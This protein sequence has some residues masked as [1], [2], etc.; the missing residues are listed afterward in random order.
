MTRYIETLKYDWQFSRGEIKNAALHTC[1]FEGWR[2]VRV[3]HDYAIEGPFDPANDRGNTIV[4]EDGFP[5]SN[6]AAGRT[7]ALPLAGTAWYR[8]TLRL[9][10]DLAGKEVSLEFDGVMSHC[11]I[12][13][14]GALVGKNIYG[15]TSFRVDVTDAVQSGDNLLAVRVEQ[16][17]WESRWYPGAGIYRNVRLIIK[18]ATSFAYHSVYLTTPTVSAENATVAISAEIARPTENLRVS[19]ALTAPD[20][21]SVGEITIP[22]TDGKIDAKLDVSTPKLWAHGTPNLY[23]ATL[24]LL[25]GDT[26]LD[27]ETLRFGIR[28]ILFDREIGCLVNGVPTR[29]KGV[30]MHHDLGAL[31][32]AVNEAALRRQFRILGEMGCNSIRTSHNPPT[33]ELLDMADELGFYIIVEQ[34]DQWKVNKT[35]NGYGLYF[36]KWA[37]FDLTSTVRRDRNHPSVILWSLGNEMGDQTA[38]DGGKTAKFLADIVRR[39]DPS[40]KITAGFSVIDGARTN[41]IVDAVDI[42]GL[43][44]R[45]HH[46]EFFHNT[47]KDILYGSETESCVSS[48]GVYF[49]PSEKAISADEKANTFVQLFDYTHRPWRR[50]PGVEI[51]APVRPDNQVSSYDL[52]A[53]N[54]A[55]FPEV[56]FAA[57]DDCPYVFGEYVWTGFDYLGEPTPY[58][59]RASQS[60][61]LSRSS[62][63]GIVDLAGLPKDRYYSYMARWTDKEVLHVFPHWNWNEGD[64]LPVHCYSSFDRAELFVNGRSLGIAEKKPQS[65]NCLERYRLIWNGVKFEP[66]EL[67]VK[68]L[69]KDGN[70]LKTT[71]VYTAEAPA[72]LELSADRTEYAADGDDLCF[73]T[74]RVLDAN[75]NPC[76]TATTRLRFSCEGAGELLATDNGDPTDLEVFGSSAR[77]AFSGMAVGIF[78]TKKDAPGKLTVRV[79]G[80]GAQSAKIALTV[81]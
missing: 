15:Y 57:Q 31:G 67:T 21:K 48:R 78:R 75:G 80:E 22:V 36:D 62:Y 13:M 59:V 1:R 16:S 28:E 70:V 26:E 34:F 20:G 65:D 49:I 14:N 52:S 7:G 44:Y 68:A 54:W 40:R 50:Y 24:R 37:D 10:E 33:P 8:K 66:G 38:K 41:G 42:V 9:P 47:T 64:V 23:F 3:P 74:V 30:C 45:A 63:F 6:E 5:A 71:S 25:E 58:G 35:T 43:N 2:T 51:P 53:P 69:D 39:E 73:V 61:K 79:D 32:A 11:E 55:Y 81:R 56:E 29:M 17:P 60:G 27:R 19:I 76:P 72:K 46:Y 12:Y 4:N 77:D 18:N